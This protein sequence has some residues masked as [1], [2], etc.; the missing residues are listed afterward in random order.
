MDAKTKGA[1]LLHHANKLLQCKYTPDFQRV[2]RA[3]KLG[4]LLSALS[5]SDEARIGPSRLLALASAAEITDLELPTI[6]QKLEDHRYIFHDEE[7]IVVL[8][9][10]S[11]TVLAHTASMFEATNPTRIESAALDLSEMVSEAPQDKGQLEEKLGDRWK[12]SKT[13]ASELLGISEGIGFV[14][15]EDVDG[16][17]KLYF[18]GNLFRRDN[19]EKTRKVLSSLTEADVRRVATVEDMLKRC[20]CVAQNEVEAELQPVLFRKLHSIGMYDVGEVENESGATSFVTR[21]ASFG[22]YGDPFTDDALDLAKAFVT[23]LTY[24]MTRSSP[25]RGQI[26]MLARLLAKL[27]AGGSVGPVTAIG[28]DYRVLEQKGVV[29]VTPHGNGTFSMQLLKR[30]VGVIALQV[31]TDGEATTASAALPGAPVSTYRR[32]E[33]SRV[34]QRKTSVKRTRKGEADVLLALRTRK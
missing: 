30:E 1:W 2:S 9:V 19:A 17:T 31:L 22:K 23:C 33:E 15:G 12:L 18:N 21:P 14:D 34:A 24:G 11:E 5:A 27:I 25:R 20:G 6:I 4:T 29:L 28:H 13:E 3:G 8:G 10:T 32:P 7:D 16:S 26:A